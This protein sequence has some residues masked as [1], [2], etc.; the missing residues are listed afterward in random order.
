MELENEP[1]FKAGAMDIPMEDRTELF[2]IILDWKYLRR[3]S[4][5]KTLYEIMLRISIY[6]KG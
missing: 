3:S 1:S 6:I 4:D 5:A 2:I